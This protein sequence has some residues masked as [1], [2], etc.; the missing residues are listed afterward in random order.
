VQ[1]ILET[2]S[3]NSLSEMIISQRILELL[4]KMELPRL[5]RSSLSGLISKVGLKKTL[6]KEVEHAPLL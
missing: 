6:L 1:T 3:T 4:L 5:K 2:N